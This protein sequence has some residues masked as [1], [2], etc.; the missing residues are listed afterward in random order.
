[1]T[2]REHAVLLLL[3][4]ALNPASAWGTGSPTGAAALSELLGS[5]DTGRISTGIL[6]DRV[7]P[8]SRIDEYDGSEA[9]PPT[10][11]RHWKQMVFEI[12]NASLAEPAWRPVREFIRSAERSV[13]FGVV[14]VAFMNV[15]Y[16]RIR[17]DALEDGT[18]TIV[19]NRLVETGP[20]PYVEKRVFAATALK[21][22]THRG[23]TVVFAFDREWYVTNEMDLPQTDKV[24]FDDGLGTREVSSGDRHTVHYPYAGRK[25]VWT[26]MIC[27]DGAVAH[28]SFYF[29]VE[30]LQ[31]PTPDDTLV[32]TA[33]IPFGGEFGTGEAYVYLSEGHTSITNPVVIVEG[34]DLDNTY[35]W[36]ELYELLN[37]ENLL[38]TIRARG[39]DAV[40][41]NFA[42]ATDYIQTNSF[43]VVE[44][45]EMIQGYVDPYRDIVVIGASMGGLCARY[46]LAYMETQGLGHR[47]RTFVSFDG[48]QGGANIPLGVQY[49]LD[50]FSDMSEDAASLLS[51]LDRPAAR[52]MLVYHHT[53][54]PGATGESDLL[55]A[56]MLSDFADAGDYPTGV[57]KVAIA[58]GSGH[59]SDQG[60]SPGD[61]IIEY[62][63]TSFLVDIIGNVWA[64]PDISDH[65]I[66]DGLID[67]ILLPTEEMP[68]YVAG[69][70][71]YDNAPGGW[72]GSMA[73]MD[74]TEAPYGDIVAIHPNHCFVPTVSALGLATGDLFY[75]I[76][77]DP[78]I[79]SLVPFD[80]VYYPAENQEHMTITTESVDWFI[81]EIDIGATSV[82]AETPPPSRLSLFPPFPNPAH[83][84]A[85]TLGFTLDRP[86]PV[87]IT[88]HDVK[89]RR[90][91]TLLDRDHGVVTGV[92]RLDTR[93]L[94]SGIYFVK[95]DAPSGSASRKFT[96][97]R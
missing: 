33:A 4:F 74:S 83:A 88:V 77:G 24:D 23:E 47:V 36:D 79:L 8:L 32:V 66:F 21:D 54:P 78:D 68:V 48:P 82:G 64:V 38:E 80:A 67:I 1:M 57:R 20:H 19:G 93:Q 75:D 56:E 12:S 55:R 37:Q 27:S 85:M 73:Q 34:F 63:Y 46:A 51:R 86:G 92:V 18:L 22:Y 70:S 5:L 9:S 97:I 39:F 31:T 90:L 42:D 14:P 16:N 3:V 44:L 35:N 71:P 62:E 96:V 91:A 89:G 52:Q 43:V 60:F 15:K 10:T 17:S 76:A 50:F 6:Y 41:L 95:M 25:T 7:V 45:L 81:T 28:G 2:L 65:I 69:T 59:G 26:R 11:L 49:W 13:A 94:A 53:S 58:N 72:R 61:Q 84:D 40:V 30:H 87:T 29:D